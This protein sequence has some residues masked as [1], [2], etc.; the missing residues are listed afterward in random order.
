M[1][2][3]NVE[4]DRSVAAFDGGMLV[5]TTG[6]YSFQL[7]VPG[8]RTLPAAGVTWVAVLPT[9]R[10]RGVLSRLMRHQLADVAARGEPLAIL[11]A[12][13]SVIYPRFGYGRG[14]WHA[15]L[16]IRRGEG[17][18]AG[19][20]PADPSLRIRIAEPA[21]ALPEMAKV[22]DAV[23]PSRPG[24][25]ARSETWWQREIFD[26]AEWRDGA[27][28][29]RCVLAEDDSGPRGY[30]LYSAVHHWDRETS[31]P[32]DADRT[33]MVAADAGARATLATHLLSRDLTA[34]FRLPDRPTDDPLLCQLADPRRARAR[35]KDG[36]WVRIIDLPAAL[37][38]RRYSAP[39]D[40]VLEVH[41]ELLPANSGRWRLATTGT[42]GDG[43]GLAASCVAAPPGAPADITL[44]VT[45]LGAAYL[46]G[47]RLGELAG[48]GLVT[49][50][51]PGAVRALSTALAWDPAPWCPVHF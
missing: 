26:P 45:E 1:I 28:P 12:S 43:S 7:S 40:V 17:V 14:M 44:G 8:G 6:A 49:E 50:A 25:V 9:H 4:F 16:T 35:L 24:F 48:A 20:V 21:A 22:Y 13:E 32:D 30:A 39:V 29:L 47:T 3:S 23:L 34:E 38:G 27:S 41:D 18:L 10:R 33:S 11:W 36:L 37:A 31:L 46:G 15:D 2:I 19:T 51:R 5:G 42:P